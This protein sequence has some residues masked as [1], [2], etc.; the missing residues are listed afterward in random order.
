MTAQPDGQLSQ[1][2]DFSQSGVGEERMANPSSGSGSQVPRLLCS[3][4]P[5]STTLARRPLRFGSHCFLSV[6]GAR[7]RDEG[8]EESGNSSA[9][10][11]G[12]TGERSAKKRDGR[13]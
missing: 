11:L 5:A 10:S 9:V 1:L 6:L 12:A 7:R 3:A 4:V 8:H 13:F 2:L